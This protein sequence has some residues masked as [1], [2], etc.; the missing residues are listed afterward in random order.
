M[1]GDAATTGESLCVFLWRCMLDDP[2][3]HGVSLLAWNVIENR[4]GST[5]GRIIQATVTDRGF[6]MDGDKSRGE[7]TH[8]MPLP[9]PPTDAK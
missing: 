2:P 9:A 8:W 4:D 7:I 1:S 3:P 5:S 6:V